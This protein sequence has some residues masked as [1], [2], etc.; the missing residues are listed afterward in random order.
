MFSAKPATWIEILGGW[1]SPPVYNHSPVGYQFL[2]IDFTCDTGRSLIALYAG[3]DLGLNFIHNR[4]GYPDLRV[5]DSTGRFFR[6]TMLGE[7][8]LAAPVPPA[9]RG[10]TLYFK[11]L[12]PLPLPY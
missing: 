8:W 4:R 6:A 7:C 10:F 9:S 11:Q 2:R 12:P 5:A 1:V 3:R